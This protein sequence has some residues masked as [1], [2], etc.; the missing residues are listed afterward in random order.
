MKDGKEGFCKECR[1]YKDLNNK[2]GVTKGC[3]E[4]YLEIVE[5]RCACCEAILSLGRYV[6][7]TF[8]SDLRV[9]H[10]HESGEIRGIVCNACNTDAIDKVEKGEGL[11]NPE[12]QKLVEEYL[13]NPPFRK[14]SGV[15]RFAP[16]GW[17]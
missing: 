3:I 8:K 13:K 11:A 4:K 7:D 1:R 6:G 15:A 9:D 5:H 10:D 14:V 2:R 16:K 12:K 17:A